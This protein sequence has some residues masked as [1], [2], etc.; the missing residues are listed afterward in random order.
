[1]LSSLISR[2]GDKWCVYNQQCF[3]FASFIHIEQDNSLIL[4]PQTVALLL[5]I[6]SSAL[7]GG[8]VDGKK[9]FRG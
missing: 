6:G 3:S 4:C 8:A 1:M 2:N 7:G 5:N 9:R